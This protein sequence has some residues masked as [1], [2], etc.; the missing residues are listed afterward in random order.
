MQHSYRWAAVQQ[1]SFA[2]ASKS[3]ARLLLASFC[4]RPCFF[5]SCLEC[6]IVLQKARKTATQQMP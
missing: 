2:K 6:C 4:T 1:A 3:K 5:I